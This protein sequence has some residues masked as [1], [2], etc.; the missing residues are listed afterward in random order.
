VTSRD[1]LSAAIRLE[2]PFGLVLAVLLG[3]CSVASPAAESPRSGDTARPP[4][5]ALPGVID[6]FK[7]GSP[8]RCSPP[9][10]SDPSKVKGSCTT[11]FDIATATLNARD[12]KHAAI[13][14]VAEFTDGNVTGPIDVTGTDEPEISPPERGTG[15]TAVF[16]FELADGTYAA[17]GVACT[18]D[19]DCVGMPTPS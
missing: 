1:S 18:D 16:V 19:G 12:P 8:M 15:A 6:G 13:V 17:V 10:D 9:T 11:Y 5:T 4:S 3:A 7:L 14:S 2:W